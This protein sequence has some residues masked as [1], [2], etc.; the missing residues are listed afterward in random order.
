MFV[1]LSL[2][3]VMVVADAAPSLGDTVQFACYS[4]FDCTGPAV[5][6]GPICT[7]GAPVDGIVSCQSFDGCLL[8]I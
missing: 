1:L 6:V 4:S 2:L 8:C 5:S 7:P 3:V